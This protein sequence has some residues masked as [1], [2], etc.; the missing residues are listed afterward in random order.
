VNKRELIDQIVAQTEVDKKTVTKVMDSFVD[1]VLATVGSKSKDPKETAVTISGFAK[2]AKVQRAARMGR[3]PQTGEPVKIK[4][5]VRPKISP[6]KEF[7]DVVT[8][9][10]PAPK[11]AKKAA[12]PAKKAAAKVAPAAPAKKAAAK[13]APAAPAA[14]AKK[15]AAKKAAKKA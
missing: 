3:N 6:L 12:A 1:V 11:L 5:S 2:F 15:A 7:K 4:A 13:A 8:G 9:A 10:A 14:P